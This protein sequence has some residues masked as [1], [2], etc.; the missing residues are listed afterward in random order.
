MLVIADSGSTKTSWRILNQGKTILDYTTEG[1]NPYLLDENQILQIVDCEDVSE[2]CNDVMEVFFYGSGCARPE[3]QELIKNALLNIF[4]AAD[5]HVNSDILGAARGVCG[6]N[7]GIVCVLGTGSNACVYNGSQIDEMSISLGYMLG[8]E[9]SGVFIGKRLLQEFLYSKLPPTIQTKFSAKYNI[10]KEEV[11]DKIY[12]QYMPNRYM[13]SFAEFAYDNLEHP[14]IYS[15]LYEG[16]YSFLENH[17]STF[18]NTDKLK[19]NFVGSIA[20]SYKNI[21]EQVTMDSG[22]TFGTVKKSPMDGLTA[23]HSHK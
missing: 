5:I 6:F 12:A 16:F 4:P 13:A 19:V 8:D 10:T 23:Y 9:G 2:Y 3:K 22:L 7:S 17:V 21:L 11:L 20:D 14:Y 15:L 1:I 18:N